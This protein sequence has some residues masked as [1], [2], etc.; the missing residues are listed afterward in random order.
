MSERMDAEKRRASSRYRHYLYRLRQSCND[1]LDTMLFNKLS[2]LIGPGRR[3]VNDACARGL[4]SRTGRFDKVV[5]VA[6]YPV[7]LGWTTRLGVSGCTDPRSI[8][9]EKN[10]LVRCELDRRRKF[11]FKTVEQKVD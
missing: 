10:V 7:I 8:S 4:E 1:D 9:V 3:R 2:P 6:E 5:A 11:S